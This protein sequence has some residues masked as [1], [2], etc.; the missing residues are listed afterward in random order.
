MFAINLGSMV[1]LIS[2]LFTWGVLPFINAAHVFMHK[3]AETLNALFAKV[4]TPMMPKVG[5]R[6]VSHY[7]PVH[8]SY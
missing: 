1:I 5:M 2:I 6:L 3:N 8:H 4:H 7:L